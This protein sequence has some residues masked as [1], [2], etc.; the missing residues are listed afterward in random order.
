MKW[1]HHHCWPRQISSN[2]SKFSYLFLLPIWW[3]RQHRLRQL[4]YSLSGWHY[5]HPWLFTPQD[6]GDIVN[7]ASTN[8]ATPSNL[9]DIVNSTDTNNILTPSG[10]PTLGFAF[11]TSL[12]WHYQCRP[13]NSPSILVSI[14]IP[15]PLCVNCMFVCGFLVNS[16]GPSR[17]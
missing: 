5:C 6:L 17:D 3:H 14:Q 16:I 13:L 2:F 1:H 10:L 15:D 8:I 12:S 7:A 9:G 4:S 11:S